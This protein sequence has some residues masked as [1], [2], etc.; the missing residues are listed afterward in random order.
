MKRMLILISVG[1][2]AVT[3]CTLINGNNHE[4][5]VARVFEHYLYPSDLADAIPEGTSSTDSMILAKRYVDTW[6]KDQLMLNRAEQALTEE[7]KDFDK[8][9]AE[10]HRSLLIFSYKQKLLQQKLD[11]VVSKEEIESYYQENI[12]NF[13]LGQ[14]VIK[15]TFVKVPLTAPRLDELRRWSRSNGEDDLDQ[16][17]KYCI[18]YAQKYSDFNNT[19]VYFSS[20]RTML[21]MT[22]SEPSRYLRYNRN[23]ETTDSLYRYFLHV[24]DHLPEGE[25]APLEMV[26]EDIVNIILNKR[27]IEFFQDLEQ[28][29]YHDGV[30]RNQFE[31][32]Q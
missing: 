10:Y 31:I 7:Q 12:N 13:L 29:V 1:L 24:S 20:I 14:D 26:S 11:T 28:R 32:Y 18:S 4:E 2:L 8:Q 9:I 16:M 27:K 30:T 22:I 3:G 25:A 21:P 17:E 15:G 5:P 19:W 23:I 6:V